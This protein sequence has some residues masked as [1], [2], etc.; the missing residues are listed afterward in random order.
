MLRENTAQLGDV[1]GKYGAVIQ[2]RTR[3]YYAPPLDELKSITSIDLK[4]SIPNI[5]QAYNS[6]E[7]PSIRE[8]KDKMVFRADSYKDG[9]Q[10]GSG[11]GLPYNGGLQYKWEEP[12]TSYFK[13]NNVYRYGAVLTVKDW[14][15]GSSE[16]KVISRSRWT[17]SAFP[18][19]T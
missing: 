13:K 11:R 1:E 9:W 19:K 14:S 6:I 17:A 7:N 2:V 15:T 8:T 12:T 3:E 5:L 10:H 16:R 4:T 18:V